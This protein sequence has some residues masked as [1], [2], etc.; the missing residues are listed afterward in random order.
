MNFKEIS[1]HV[2]RVNILR[3]MVKEVGDYLNCVGNKP[4]SGYI[5][6]EGKTYR[7]WEPE[8]VKVLTEIKNKNEEEL[9]NL[10][11]VE[12]YIKGME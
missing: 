4:D 2:N 3:R 10:E 9:R 6:V 8:E 11:S 7:H 1:D 12:F 5:W